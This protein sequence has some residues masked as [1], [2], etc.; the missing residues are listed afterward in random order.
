MEC[1]CICYRTSSG[2]GHPFEELDLD[3]AAMLEESVTLLKVVATCQGTFPLMMLF[4]TCS[5]LLSELL[6]VRHDLLTGSGLVLSLVIA[7]GM[8]E[9]SCLVDKASHTACIWQLYHVRSRPSLG[10]VCVH[11]AASA[12]MSAFAG[13]RP[14]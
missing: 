8:T 12:L 9:A 3:V 10:A 4:L 13:L 11:I 7:W 1:Q 5:E 2:S 14:P 6:V